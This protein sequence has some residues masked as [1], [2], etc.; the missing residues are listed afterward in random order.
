MTGKRWF[1]WLG[2]LHGSRKLQKRHQQW[3]V[4]AQEAYLAGWYTGLNDVSRSD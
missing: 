2:K 1:Y 3:P 4:F